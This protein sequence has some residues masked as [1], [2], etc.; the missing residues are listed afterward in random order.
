MPVIDTAFV[1][2][3]RRVCA[4]LFFAASLLLFAPVAWAEASGE[5]TVQSAQFAS[6]QSTVAELR[7]VLEEQQSLMTQQSRQLEA[8]GREIDVLRRR[9]DEPR[10]TTP[11]SAQT[12]PAQPV[13]TR[14]EAVEQAIKHLPELPET[15][16]TA[17]DFPGSIRLPEPMPL[18]KSEGRRASPRAYARPAGNRRPFH[19]ILDSGR[20]SACRRRVSSQVHRHA[21]RVNVD[22]R[23]P[24]P[25]GGMRTFVESDFAGSET[26]ERLRHA[27]IQTNRWLF[28]QTW[29]TFSDPEADP[30][31]I[32]FEG[33]NAISRLRQAQFR[34]TRRPRDHFSLALALE[35]PAPDL[36]G[37]EGINLT[38]DFVARI[39]WEPEDRPKVAL[40]QSAH[41]QGAILVRALRGAS[42]GQ[43]DVTL[44]TGAFGVN[45]SGVVSPPWA[46]GDRIK[47]ATNN[48]WGI[49][50]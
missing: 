3:T 25:F 30:M 42:T 38:P 15:L 6:L 26:T 10:T 39:R 21:T 43:P 36:T 49:G 7:R 37:A 31:D 34:Y 19:R 4:L 32:D 20:K 28:G 33:L 17:G 23:W 14:L 44:S 18:S 48:G 47:F 50:R 35:N 22:M 9:L 41:I 2:C 13:E 12:V 27:Y 45:V 11:G 16:A 24:S 40:T 5:E 29:S 8:Q 1:F 46:A